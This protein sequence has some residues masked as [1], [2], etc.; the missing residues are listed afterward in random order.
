M[1]LSRFAPNLNKNLDC[2]ADFNIG[3]NRKLEGY[4]TS[5]YDIEDEVDNYRFN[6]KLDIPEKSGE[7]YIVAESYYLNQV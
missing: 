7:F 1:P 3:H 6:F 5:W 4:T 2:F